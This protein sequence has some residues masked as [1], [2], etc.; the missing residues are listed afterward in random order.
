MNFKNYLLVFCAALISVTLSAQ[1]ETQNQSQGVAN[2]GESLP[3]YY[4]P[5]MASRSELIPAEYTEE[6]ARDRR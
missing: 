5:S 2:F 4:V 6:E 3:K 1:E